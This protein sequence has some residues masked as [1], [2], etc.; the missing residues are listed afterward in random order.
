MKAPCVA[1]PAM[2]TPQQ[3]VE[4]S[5]AQERFVGALAHVVLPYWR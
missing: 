4:A 3:A 5:L 2:E 1:W